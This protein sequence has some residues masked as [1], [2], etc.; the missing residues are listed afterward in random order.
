ML[1]REAR[2]S[3][4]GGNL[5]LCW[6][7]VGV[8]C[9]SWAL[10]SRILRSCCVRFRFWSVFL[11]L[12]ALH[13]RFRRA[14]GRSEEGF[15]GSSGLFFQVFSCFRVHAR[16]RCAKAPD[17]QKPQFFPGFFLCFKQIAHVARKRKNSTISLLKPVEQSSPPKSCSKPVLERA[18]L[19]TGGV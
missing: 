3:R 1:L 10:P 12:G 2:A 14:Q 9:R 18:R 15:G 19:Y 11:H 13:G 16:W 8:S 6:R 17:M 5:A 7:Y 4:R